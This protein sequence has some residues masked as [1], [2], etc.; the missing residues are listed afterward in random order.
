MA[1]PAV[2]DLD[3]ERHI[4]RVVGGHVLDHVELQATQHLPHRVVVGTV[5]S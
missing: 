4:L 2:E 3:H 1:D 5:G